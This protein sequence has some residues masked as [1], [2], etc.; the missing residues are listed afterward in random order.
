MTSSLVYDK[1][2]IRD[3]LKVV[4]AMNIVLKALAYGET[5]EIEGKRIQMQKGLLYC[6]GWN[7][8]NGEFIDPVE[9]DHSA[10][11][12]MSHMPWEYWVSTIGEIS[13]ERLNEI[14]TLYAVKA[15]LNNL[16]NPVRVPH[17]DSWDA[18]SND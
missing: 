5:I 2:D 4:D 14:K 7:Y 12:G 18:D 15:T 1:D 6:K 10:H 8:K 17:L 16:N 11:L 13:P 9:G 3:N